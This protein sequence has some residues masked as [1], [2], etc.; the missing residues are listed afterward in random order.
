M[1]LTDNRRIQEKGR[2][3]PTSVGGRHVFIKTH[4]PLF[5]NEQ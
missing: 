2:V 4:L 3:D 5:L 1:G